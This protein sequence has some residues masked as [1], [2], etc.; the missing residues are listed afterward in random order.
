MSELAPPSPAG[1]SRNTSAAKIRHGLSA[2]L[3]WLVA[4]LFLT[5]LI[6]TVATSLKPASD[7]F[8]VPPSLVGKEIRWQ[9]YADALDYLPFQ[10]FILN[11]LIVAVSG[12][13]ITLAAASMSA[14]AFARLKFR[15]RN[16]LFA[17][18]LATLMIPQEVLVVPMFSLMQEFGWV[19]SYRALILP[20]AF[21]AF[22]VFLMRQFFLTIPQELADAAYIDGAGKFRTFFSIM[23][24]L[25]RPS[26][27]VLAVFTFIN[28]WNSFLWPLIITNSVEDKGTV[29]LGLSL[30]FSQQGSQWNLVMAASVISMIPTV[31]LLLLLR[32]HLVSGIATTGMGGR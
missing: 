19:D 6:Y 15:G 16:V 23:L 2:T 26:L 9:N 10:K 30:F 18:F 21:T 24:P 8:S 31:L 25:A 5:P 28:Y 3:L 17:A 29:P 32:K 13:L 14:Y 1:R 11:G 12:T 7:V 4:L 20:W 27:A 22:G